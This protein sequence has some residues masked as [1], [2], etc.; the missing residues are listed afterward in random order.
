MSIYIH[1]INQQ[2]A[3]KISKQ[4]QLQADVYFVNH[5][6]HDR[7]YC[8]LLQPLKFNCLL[9]F[10]DLISSLKS[11]LA[12]CVCCKWKFTLLLRVWWQTELPFNTTIKMLFDE[13]R[14]WVSKIQTQS[15]R[16]YA[17]RS[18]VDPKELVH[19]T[20]SLMIHRSRSRISR[21]KHYSY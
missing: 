10:I 16:L 4:W 19:R 21:G 18:E 7:Q 9:I 17:Q 6:Y 12:N 13:R 14:A 8:H 1:W 11:R 2:S 15:W 3:V 5:E 20:R